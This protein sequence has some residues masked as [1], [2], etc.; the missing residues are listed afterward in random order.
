VTDERHGAAHVQRV[1]PGYLDRYPAKMVSRL[2]DRLISEFCGDCK[3]VFDP[4][5]G[6]GA[7]LLAARNVGIPAVGFDVNP[8]AA[9]LTEVKVNGFDVGRATEIAV[10]CVASA[11]KSSIRSTIPW[12]NKWY[13]FTPKTIE[14]F[15]R[16]RAVLKERK[17]ALSVEGRAVLLAYALSVRRCSRADQRSPKPF[18]SKHAV[19][20]RAG[21]HYDPF[22][23]L[24]RLLSELGANY[25]RQER[26]DV[27]VVVQDSRAPACRQQ[28]V[29]THLVTSPPYLNAQD[30]F[31][32]FKLELFF[33]HDLL[34]FDLADV[35]HRLIGTERG[36]MDGSA[37]RRMQSR[38]GAWVPGWDRL[39]QKKPREA[40]VIARYLADMERAFR[41]L[42]RHLCKGGKV[43][44]VCGDNMI[45]GLHVITWRLL[46]A[47][48]EERLGYV[49]CGRYFDRI[50]RRSVP[51]VRMGHRAIIK[52]ETISI[53]RK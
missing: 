26:A 41:N 28:F 23:E 21:R 37:V 19:A 14:K 22:A 34:P 17:L 42:D 52:T 30:Y 10:A 7:V 43:V 27:T 18:I 16:L 46:N 49:V 33:L 3:L 4:F 35:E 11:K 9:L 53:L 39:C 2:A 25:R 20:S 24:V 15:E 47:M 36:I 6:S 13:W 48:L 31:R 45:G 32:N 40:W 8:Y 38:Y 1:I 5:C 12:S 29:A 44:L 51:P 50:R